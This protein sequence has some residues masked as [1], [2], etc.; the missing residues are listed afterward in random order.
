[1]LFNTVSLKYNIKNNIII[2]GV[3]GKY[4]NGLYEK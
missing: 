3:C 2:K 1:M 4:L